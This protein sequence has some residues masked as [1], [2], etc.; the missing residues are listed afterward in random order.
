MQ[1][2]A[3]GSCQDGLHIPACLSDWGGDRREGRAPEDVNGEGALAPFPH[4]S[5]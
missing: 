5:L 2:A 1:S 4:P 3:G